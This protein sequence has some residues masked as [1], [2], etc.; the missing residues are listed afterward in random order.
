LTGTRGR[1][2]GPQEGSEVKRFVKYLGVIAAVASAGCL[3][4]MAKDTPNIGAIQAGEPYLKSDIWKDVDNPTI[5]LPGPIESAVAGASR[6]SGPIALPPSKGSM[7][8]N[9][10]TG[11][12]AIPGTHLG[13]FLSPQERTGISVKKA[14]RNLG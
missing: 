1:I 4:A 2:G 5:G 13:S 10:A 14:I 7:N 6:E 12:S 8:T 9:A 3:F 11:A